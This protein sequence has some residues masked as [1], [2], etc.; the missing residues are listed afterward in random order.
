[1]WALSGLCPWGCWVRCQAG[2]LWCGYSASE[3][4]A[5][6]VRDIVHRIYACWPTLRGLTTYMGWTSVGGAGVRTALAEQRRSSPTTF[7]RK[8]NP[9]SEIDIWQ[10]L[11]EQRL[12]AHRL[13]SPSFTVIVTV[14]AT[15][16]WLR[17]R[18]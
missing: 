3:G 5:T 12:P 4:V 17:L 7:A 16:R 1:M 13:T 15:Y 9:V 10:K 11:G 14:G 2:P 8:V 6:L 18:R